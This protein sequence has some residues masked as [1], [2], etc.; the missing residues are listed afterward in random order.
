MNDMIRDSIWSIQETFGLSASSV[1][2]IFVIALTYLCIFFFMTK[3]YGNS[4]DEK[5]RIIVASIPVFITIVGG[6]IFLDRKSLEMQNSFGQQQLKACVEIST[7]AG[8]LA[9]SYANLPHSKEEY[10]KDR[11]LF[12]R[13]YYGSILIFSDKNIA[14]SLRSYFLAGKR[15]KLT[16]SGELPNFDSATHLNI[17]EHL[18][19]KSIEIAFACR[20]SEE[21]KWRIKPLPKKSVYTD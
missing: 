4:F 18:L 17:S 10:L 13:S 9:V 20:R 6:V 8:G 2:I 21:G 14:E 7:L 11:T 12:L 3:R 5:F 15:F 19:N 16:S 1:A